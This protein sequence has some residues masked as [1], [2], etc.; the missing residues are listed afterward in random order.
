[1]V[2]ATRVVV[3]VV[4]RV[5]AAAR[6]IVAADESHGVVDDDDFLMVRAADRMLVV[7]A[8]RQPTMRAAVEL[9]DRQPLAL[10][11]VEHREVPRQHVTAQCRGSRDEGIEEIAQLLGQ[12]VARAVGYEAHAAV[13]VPAEDENRPAGPRKRRTHGAEVL[14]AIDQK[15][16]AL[17]TLDTPAV[18][19][20]RQQRSV[21]VR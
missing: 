12:P 13:D 16:H 15:R 18:A 17:R 3:R 14:D 20:R 2:D 19:P 9:V 8:K 1:M 5:E 10:H 11:R 7:E 4:A 21:S 6:E